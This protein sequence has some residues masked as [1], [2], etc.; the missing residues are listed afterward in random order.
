MSL[1][2]F[3][4]EVIPFMKKNSSVWSDEESNKLFPNII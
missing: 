3:D 2:D 1:H 4:A